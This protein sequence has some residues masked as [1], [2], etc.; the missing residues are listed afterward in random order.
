V[1][2]P[3]SGNTA[4]A[5]HAVSV[6]LGAAAAVPLFLIVR[7]LF[8]R[9]IALVT[10]L[11]YAFQPKIVDV[12]SDVMTE[13]T[14]FFF[15]LSSMWLTWQAAEEPSLDR[16][17]V[18]AGAA[19]AAF[20]TRAEGVLAL[21]LAV[22]WPAWETVRRRKWDAVRIGSVLLTPVV[23]VLLLS[24]YLWW[25]RS[26]KGHWSLSVRPSLDSAERAAGT[27][28]GS[29]GGGEA[30]GSLYIKYLQSILRMSLYGVLF[31]LYLLGLP[32]LK[33]LGIRKGLFYAAFAGGWMGGVWLTLRQH[34][35]MS[36]R[37][38]F[39]GMTLLS[40]IAAAG[41]LSAFELAERRWPAARWRPAACWTVL[42]LVAVAPGARWLTVRR[43]ENRSYVDA[44]RWIRAQGRP[45]TVI[46]GTA[47]VAYLASAWP[48][49]PPED[50]A[51]AVR[52]V[53]QGHVGC[54]VYDER[55][56]KSLP[57][58]VKMLRDAEFLEPP[59]RVTG[60]PGTLDVFVQF[61]KAP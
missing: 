46:S 16:A 15:F 29:Q 59:V 26:V 25:V 3:V 60:S 37:Y 21:V 56:V 51:D 27:W 9:P 42:F 5:G 4:L 20:L 53:T 48:A 22:A 17:V 58:M 11:M 28:I 31:P 55:D 38:L 40:A 18:L 32:S 23:M 10:A 41:L 44:A 45:V 33:R 50:R 6:V 13:G 30:W 12:Q 35:A 36:D 52:L 24:P 39:I 49:Y 34:N 57:A 14:F 7:E 61:V 1:I 47:Q 8:G 54:F 43:A 19:A 2:R